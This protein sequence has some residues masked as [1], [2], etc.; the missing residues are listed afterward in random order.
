MAYQYAQADEENLKLI[1]PYMSVTYMHMKFEVYFFI[2]VII[3]LIFIH[4]VLFF[5]ENNFLF[6]ILLTF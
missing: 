3:R 6:N 1:R 4:M 2:K 5:Y